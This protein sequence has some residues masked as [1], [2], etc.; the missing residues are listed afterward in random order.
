MSKDQAVYVPLQHLLQEFRTQSF[1][2][3]FVKAFRA[4]YNFAG[5]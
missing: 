4:I 3:A 5:P 2:S 1:R